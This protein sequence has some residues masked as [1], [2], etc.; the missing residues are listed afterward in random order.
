MCGRMT[1]VTDPAEV[2]RIFDADVRLDADGAGRGA[3]LQR[4]AHAAA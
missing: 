1:Q 2:A 3:A 4:G